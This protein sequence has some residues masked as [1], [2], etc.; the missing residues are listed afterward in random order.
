MSLF[1]CIAAASTIGTSSFNVMGDFSRAEFHW[2]WN[3][4]LPEK[5]PQTQLSD[6]SDVTTAS[7]T[8]RFTCINMEVPFHSAANWCHHSMSERADKLRCKWRSSLVAH[9]ERS[10]SRCKK[11]RPRRTA[12]HACWRELIRDSS[13]L[14]E[15]A[16]LPLQSCTCFLNCCSL[17]SGNHISIANV[18]NSIPKKRMVVAGPSHLPFSVGV[19]VSLHICCMIFILISHSE[20]PGL[21][22]VMKSSR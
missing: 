1:Y 22:T 2:S 14:F 21:P 6:A 13:S 10:I 4:W 7:G 11:D 17:S 3:H 16:F 20:E 19:P 9:L 18:S 15:T 5:A 8:F 12:L